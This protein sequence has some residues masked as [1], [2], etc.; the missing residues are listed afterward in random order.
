MSPNKPLPAATD[1]VDARRKPGH[2]TV[3]T[4]QGEWAEGSTIKM[5]FGE[6]VARSDC[7]AVGFQHVTPDD[8]TSDANSAPVVEEAPTAAPAEGG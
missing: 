4:D 3:Y 8:L 6:A 1:I 2:G 7:Y 5:T